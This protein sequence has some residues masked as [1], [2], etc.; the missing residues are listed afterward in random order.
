MRITSLYG[1]TNCNEDFE[2]A[3]ITPHRHQLIGLELN[4]CLELIPVGAE[5]IDLAE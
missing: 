5:G 3:Y 1:H 2:G 4:L